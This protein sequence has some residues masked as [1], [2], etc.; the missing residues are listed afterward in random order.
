MDRFVIPLDSSWKE[1]F[2][3]FLIINSCYNVYV[4]AY[5]AAFRSPTGKVEII[6]EYVIEGMFLLD[7]IF[8]FF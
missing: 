6:L 1:M 8:C 7:M 3:L 4:N 5:Y 2:D